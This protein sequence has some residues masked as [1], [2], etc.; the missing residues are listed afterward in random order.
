MMS[1]RLKEVSLFYE[2]R[3]ELDGTAIFNRLK[4]E[5]MERR[6]KPNVK[7]YLGPLAVALFSLFLLAGTATAAN[8]I[9]IG[10]SGPM[11]FP[12][13]EHMY[14]GAQMAADEINAKGGIKI[15][16]APYLLEIVKADSNEFLSVP[17]AVSTFERLTTVDKVNFIIGGGRSEANLAQQEVMAEHK[18]I[19]IH[20]GGGS[21]TLTEQAGKNFDKYKYFFRSTTPHVLSQLGSLTATLD[22][23]ANKIRKDLGIKTPK[24]AIMFEKIVSTDAMIP[25]CQSVLPKLGMEIVGVWRP[26][27]TAN[28][29]SAELSAIKASGAQIIFTYFTGPEGIIFG[30]QWGELEIPAIPVGVNVEA[31]SKRYWNQT[32]GKCEY[33]ITLTAIARAKISPH[34]IQT[35]DKFVK[36]KG[37]SPVYTGMGAYDAVYIWTQAAERAQSLDSD[38][39][40]LELEKTDYRGVSGRNV[41]N[42]RNDKRPHDVRYGAGYLTTFGQQWQTGDLVLIWPDGNEVNPIIGAGTG[43]K[44]F[45]YEGTGDLKLP[46]VMIKYWGR[47]K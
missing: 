17:D 19:F 20:I 10:V 11:K 33:E 44:G 38:K 5:I 3:S 35:Y 30:K 18:I 39:L 21:N 41:F 34:T 43:W 4:E 12:A 29:V 37:D 14:I 24:V 15:G 25:Y 8:I 47:T 23:V 42:D 46:P 22:M 27:P 9:K 40:V 6:T 31:Q 16:G 7:F 13:G 1:M 28:D 36:I 2:G 45:R 32:A 26:S